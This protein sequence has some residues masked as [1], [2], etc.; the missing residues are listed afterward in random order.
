MTLPVLALHLA[1]TWFMTGLIWLIQLVHY[2]LFSQVGPERFVAYHHAHSTLITLIVGPVMLL[3][4]AT[5]VYL[6]AAFVA[7]PRA[8]VWWLAGGLL[9]IVWLSTAFLQVPMHA[10]LSQGFDP[11]AHARLVDTNWIRTVGWSARAVL[12]TAWWVLRAP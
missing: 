4:A 12:V 11:A 3:E 5:A 10:V 1:A 7:E 8:W 9:G 6:L 2:P